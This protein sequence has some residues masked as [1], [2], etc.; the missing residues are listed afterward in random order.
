MNVNPAAYNL[1]SHILTAARRVRQ[2][3]TPRKQSGKNLS[4]S[5]AQGRPRC[6]LTSRIGPD[7]IWTLGFC[8][9][10]SG[11]VGS[12]AAGSRQGHGDGFFLASINCRLAFPSS[13]F[14][15]FSRGAHCSHL[16]LPLS[17]SLV[18]P[19]A[20]NISSSTRAYLQLL[21]P[22][23][24]QWPFWLRSDLTSCCFKRT[25]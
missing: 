5:T 18:G 2:L 15:T 20:R 8:L 6:K 23:K 25:Q 21:Q 17:L 10:N 12:A 3:S 11:F 4:V 16:L 24:Q 19:T 1:C 7:W 22:H 13:F 9:E 14:I